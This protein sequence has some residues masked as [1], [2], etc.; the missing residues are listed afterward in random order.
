[1]TR[2]SSPPKAA[3]I[4]LERGRR[5]DQ[6]IARF[7]A[8]ERGVDARQAIDEVAARLGLKPWVRSQ[9]R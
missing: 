6:A 2:D 5:W 3:A 7:D 4:E 8:G 9:V 1:M